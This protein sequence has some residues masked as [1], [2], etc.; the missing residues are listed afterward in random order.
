MSKEE[1]DI[2]KKSKRRTFVR[3]NCNKVWCFQCSVCLK[4]HYKYAAH[5]CCYRRWCDIC[6]FPYES[7]RALREHAK[8][9]H[10]NQFC[11]VCNQVFENLKIHKSSA[12]HKANITNTMKNKIND[13][14]HSLNII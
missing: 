1:Y 2:G 13:E 14:Q 4:K 3:P 11:E 10:P 7:E 8:K 6:Q 12:S 5:G 9:E